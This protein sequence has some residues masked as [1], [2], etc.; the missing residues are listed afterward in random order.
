[1]GRPKKAKAVPPK[2]I[3][4]AAPATDKKIR[5]PF[6]YLRAA[7]RM[8]YDCQRMRLQAQGRLT[9]K[10]KG[11][12]IKLHPEDKKLI[13]LRYRDMHA[14]EKEML[15]DVK[16]A[17]R[18][19]PFYTQVLCP[20]S[21]TGKGKPRHKGLGPTMSAVILS[22]FDIRKWETV[23]KGWMFAGLA[24]VPATR[25]KK[26]QRLVN[27]AD[28][29]SDSFKH[30][31]K[32]P[33]KGCE[34]I[35]RASE[36]FASGKAMRPVPG[37][38]LR[39]NS[40]LRTKLVGVLAPVL[41]KCKSP[42]TKFYYN[43]KNRRISQTLYSPDGWGTSDAHRHADAMRY[44]IKMMLLDIW[45]QWRRFESL[46]VRPPYQEEYLGKKHHASANGKDSKPKTGDQDLDNEDLDP[47]IE[48]ELETLE[49]DDSLDVRM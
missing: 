47:A 45:E 33:P 11:A 15:N 28:A 22:E 35:I 31:G 21:A 36:T 43:M 24:P 25:C 14:L 26:C 41:L 6:T 23:S 8:F 1:M 7:V 40:F 42:L 37:E 48:A 9:P 29:T 20:G 38:K 16:D 10:A 30:L 49:D 13:E 32:G 17:L 5:E 2:K 19:I 27:P 44:M 12:E 3:K 46:E 34:M 39:Y 4:T 18:E